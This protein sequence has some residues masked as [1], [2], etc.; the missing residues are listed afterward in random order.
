V[1]QLY[2]QAPG[3]HFSR[4]LRHAWVTVELFSFPGHHTGILL[5]TDSIYVKFVGHNFEAMHKFSPISTSLLQENSG[6]RQQ[7]QNHRHNKI[8]PVTN[9]LTPSSGVLLEKLCHSAS[10]EIPRLLCNPKL[11]YCVHKSPPL[12]LSST[13]RI[14]SKASHSTFLRSIIT[15]YSHLFY[16]PKFCMNFSSLPCVLHPQLISSSLIWSPYNKWWKIR[17]LKVLIM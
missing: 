16:Q 10:Q 13:R 3:T 1:A 4:L 8:G 6:A 11:H 7:N 5:S 14:Q 17:S 9:Q 15:L 2:P 12:V